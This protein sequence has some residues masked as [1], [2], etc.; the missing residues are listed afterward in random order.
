MPAVEQRSYTAEVQTYTDSLATNTYARALQ[1]DAAQ[2]ERREQPEQRR[3]PKP[4]T[5]CRPEDWEKLEKRKK[6]EESSDAADADAA[7]HPRK[8]MK[9]LRP[10]QDEQEPAK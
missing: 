8:V 7:A 2:G 3:Q 1:Q 6:I 5:K 10:G 9:M 4:P